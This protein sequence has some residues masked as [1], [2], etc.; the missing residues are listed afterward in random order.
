MTTMSGRVFGALRVEW[1][2]ASGKRAN[3]TRRHCRSSGLSPTARAGTL[4]GAALLA[5]VSLATLAT[6]MSSAA[7]AVDGTWSG[8][9]AEWT[10]G[11]NW[12][13][14]PDV[15]DDTAT[16]TNN[17]APTSVT[18][19]NDASINTIQFTAGAPAFD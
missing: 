13:S 4:P 7:Q 5:G 15:P 16:F 9:G 12:S 10:D 14:N 18:I 3:D 1:P 19:S 6:L 11:T 17:A 8:P 2:T